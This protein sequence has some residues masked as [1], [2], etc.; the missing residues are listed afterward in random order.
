ML[1]EKINNVEKEKRNF[2]LGDCGKILNGKSKSYVTE[3][4]DEDKP[5]KQAKLKK[6]NAVVHESSQPVNCP[7]CNKRFFGIHEL[8]RHIS[9]VH[10]KNENFKC[11]KCDKKNW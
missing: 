4:H 10:E 7:T 6:H 11:P 3:V 1:N 2:S 8:N 5:P 9:A